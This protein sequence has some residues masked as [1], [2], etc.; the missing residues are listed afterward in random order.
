MMKRP[1]K[2]R[3]T[4]IG[5]AN[6]QTAYGP[7]DIVLTMYTGWNVTIPGLPA[8]D[9]GGNPISYSVV[10]EYVP[11]YTVNYASSDNTITMTNTLD[12]DAPTTNWQTMS[13]AG[14]GNARQTGD[15]VN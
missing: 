1:V 2:V 11:G 12:A 14:S 4:L 10:E 13:L 8:R 15:C 9:G 6:Q 3:V 5:T 7:M